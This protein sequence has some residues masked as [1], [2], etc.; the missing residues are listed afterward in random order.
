[1]LLGEGLGMT[2][3]SN[4]NSLNIIQWIDLSANIYCI[5]GLQEQG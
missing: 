5:D 1:M 3:L 4:N 2:Y